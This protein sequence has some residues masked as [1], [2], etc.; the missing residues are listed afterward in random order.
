VGNAVELAVIWALRRVQRGE[1]VAAEDAYKQAAKPFLNRRWLES[2][3]KLWKESP[4]KFCCL[5]EHYYPLHHKTSEQDMILRMTEQVKTC[6]SHF[7]DNTAPRLKDVPPGC[8]LPIARMSNG[9]PESLELDGIKVYA[10]PDY[11]YKIDGEI[12]IHDW[13]S[14]KP[15]PFHEEQMALYGV[16]ASLKHGGIAGHIHAHL[17]YLLTGETRSAVLGESDAGFVRDAIT[18][19]AREMAEYLV[20]CDIAR[21]VPLP[22]EDWEMSADRDICRR[23]NF[24]ELCKPEL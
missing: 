5:H 2:R 14:G 11:A 7:I 22:V 17:E 16:W 10:I 8:E 9:D 12:H 3:K 21:N 13:K 23:C 1:P 19:S 15:K 6:I 18:R 24:Y 4:K 20:D